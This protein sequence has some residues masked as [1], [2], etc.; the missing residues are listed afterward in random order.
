MAV[1]DEAVVALRAYLTARTRDGS[2]DAERGFLTPSRTDHL[3]APASQH[4]G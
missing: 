1:T 3:D 2:K 4:L